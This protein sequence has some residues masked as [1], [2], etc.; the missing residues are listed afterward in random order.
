MH[1]PRTVAFDIK[2]P[3][4]QLT[5]ADSRRTW[6]RFYWP[7]W[8]TIWHV[9]PEKDGTDDSCGWFQRARHLNPAYLARVRSEF[10]F[11]WDRDR[12]CWFRDAPDQMPRL[13]TISITLQM[14]RLAAKAYYTGRRFDRHGW[15][16]MRRFMRRHLDEVLAFAENPLDSMRPFIEQIY[17][18]TDDS[19]E[20]RI[21]HAA[22]IVG[23][24]VARWEQPWYRHPRWHVWHWRIQVHPLQLF[25]RWAFS[26][27]E[28][29]GK[30]FAYGYAPTSHSW[31][32]TG[33]RWFRSEPGV[34]HGD[35]SRE[36]R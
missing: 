22:A 16:G 24:C 8:I 25:K 31:H 3:W 29:C 10:A 27:C 23:A 11:F 36:P 32:G 28:K 4:P 18:N 7:T 6:G 20:E 30:G 19:R 12:C 2:R 9:D 5:D 26:R 1:D 34:F 33:P 35:C 21:A 13:S 14:F 17:G 15:R